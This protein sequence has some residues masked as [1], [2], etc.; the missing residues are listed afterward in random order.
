MTKRER[1][2]IIYQ[3]LRAE[4]GDE[5]RGLKNLAKA[6]GIG[7]SSAC[8]DLK[9]KEIDIE[10]FKRGRPVTAYTDNVAKYL[11]AS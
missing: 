11:A 4:Y 10:T 3:R 7:Y 9:S 8:R 6:L 2:K 5:I 1:E